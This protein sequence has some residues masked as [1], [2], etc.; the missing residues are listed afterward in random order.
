M[1]KTTVLLRDDS[2]GTI[3]NTVDQPPFKL[4]GQ[5]E[6]GNVELWRADGRWREDGSDHPYDIVA[7]QKSDGTLVKVQGAIV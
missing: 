7:V 6:R 2:V 5:H 4:V 1:I 3:T